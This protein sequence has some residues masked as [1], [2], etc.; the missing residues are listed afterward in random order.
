MLAAVPSVVIG[1][2]GIFV[3]GPFMRSA[4]SSRSSSRSSAGSRSSPARRSR[5]ACCIAIVVLTIMMIPITSSIC[6]ELFVSVPKDVKEASIGLGATRWEMVRGVVVPYVQGGVVAAVTLGL[7]RALGEAIAVT[8]VIGNS[9]QPFHVSLFAPGNTLA[10]QLAS[11]YQSA[12]TNIELSSLVYLGLILLVI[13]F[14]TNLVAQRIVH[15]FDAPAGRVSADGAQPSRSRRPGA[16]GGGCVINRAREG[17]PRSAPRCSRSA[18][19]VILV[20]SVL[21]KALPTRSTGTSSSRAR[22]SSGRPA[23]A[24]RP[25]FVGTIMLVAIATAIALPIGVLVAIYVSEFAP[26]RIADQIKLWLDVLNGVPVDRDRHLRLRA[27]RLG[28]RSRCSGSATTRARG[29]AASRSSIIMLPL[30]ARTTM[31]VLALVPNSL[32]EA[33]YALGVSKWRTVAQR[34]PADRARRHRH[35]HD[36]RRRARRRR[37]GAAPLHL[38]DLRAGRHRPTRRSRS[39]R[40]R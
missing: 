37:D 24:S 25:A 6:R 35:R 38:L 26:Q 14:I 13:T 27:R 10:S 4:R 16:R 32:R 30:V 28:T 34:R 20:G 15:R 22:P 17:A 18:C 33:S 36:A 21:V 31:E 9:L 23:A 1:L 3:L 39:P 7:G 19:S 12:P 8:Q 11:S 40:S 5:P 29:Q 2:W